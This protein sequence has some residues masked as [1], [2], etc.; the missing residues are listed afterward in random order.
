MPVQKKS[1][2][3][4]KA[5][6]TLRLLSQ[7]IENHFE[8]LKIKLQLGDLFQEPSMFAYRKRKNLRDMIGSNKIL[9]NKVIPN[10][11]KEKC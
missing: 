8:I 1:G 2:N 3:L 10:Q 11:S 5:P 9:S 4:L 6:R 7:V